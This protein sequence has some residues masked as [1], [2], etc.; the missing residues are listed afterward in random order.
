MIF[1]LLKKAKK[2]KLLHYMRKLLCL[3]EK[4]NSKMLSKI[5]FVGFDRQKCKF[6]LSIKTKV[7]TI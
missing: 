3:E 6:N 5:N 1:L 7:F 4:R 2:G